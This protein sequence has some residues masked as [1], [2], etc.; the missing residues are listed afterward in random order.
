MSCLVEQRLNGA[1]VDTSRYYQAACHQKGGTGAATK[2]SP[3]AITWDEFRYEI[4]AAAQPPVR[5]MQIG[6]DELTV[7]PQPLCEE[8][9]HAGALLQIQQL[10]SLAYN[11]YGYGC[12]RRSIA[13]TQ[14]RRFG[15]HVQRC[16][17]SCSS[18]SGSGRS[19]GRQMLSWRKR[20]HEYTLSELQECLE[21][22]KHKDR[23]D[24]LLLGDLFG[25][26]GLQSV[27]E[28]RDLASAN[29]TGDISLCTLL[30]SSALH[31]FAHQ[32]AHSFQPPLSSSEPLQGLTHGV[33]AV[34]FRRGD[35]F[36]FCGGLRQCFVPLAIATRCILAHA[37]RRGQSSLFV[38]SD[39]DSRE[40]VYLTY[41]LQKHGVNAI[42][43]PD[44]RNGA[45]LKPI[46]DTL[47]PTSLAS[48]R[49]ALTVI[50]KLLCA[51]A[52]YFIGTS[53][54]TFSNQV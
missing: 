32:V 10:H 8:G 31:E 40:T 41:L 15:V 12:P 13:L 17:S 44:I 29:D 14:L 3:L 33:G 52:E 34:H 26:E 49:H 25:V 50:D 51:E 54:S 9:P 38:A 35:W 23:P 21:P 42:S 47:S 46:D 1:D 19:A 53:G 24:V 7:V 43:L 11:R 5:L 16:V 39:G 20:K 28:L 22:P 48:D 36:Q 6:Q 30:P 18:T 2:P 4:C 45:T 37:L 27:S